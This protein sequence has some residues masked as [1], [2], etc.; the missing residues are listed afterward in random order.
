M[1]NIDLT[2]IHRMMTR[3]YGSRKMNVETIVERVS[4]IKPRE[5]KITFD[6]DKECFVDMVRLNRRLNRYIG[7]V[8]HFF[9]SVNYK[10]IEI[11]VI[12][13][14]RRKLRDYDFEFSDN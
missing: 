11:H 6:Y 9:V 1:I 8:R 13:Y 14:W 7:G 12:F 10:S 5:L 4:F 3:H 2:A